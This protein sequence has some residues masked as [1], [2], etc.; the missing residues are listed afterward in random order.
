[1]ST[2]TFLGAAQRVTGSCYLIRCGERQ[3]LLECGMLQGEN[4]NGK[5]GKR[6]KSNNKGQNETRFPF[7]VGEIDAVI[8]SHA[9][10]DHSGMLPLL[11]KQGY[12][13]PIYMTLQTQALLPTMHK[14]AAF[15]QEK[16]AE[17]ENKRRARAGKKAVEPLFDIND[18]ERELGLC[19]GLAYGAESEI[20]PG[21]RLR[22]REA[23]HILGSAIVELWFDDKGETRKLVFS[24]DLGNSH[25]PLMRDPAIITEADLLLLESTYG[26]RDHQPLEQTLDE[27]R[28]ALDAAAASG[29]NV[30]IPSFAVGRTQDLIYHLGQLYH[31]GQLK[32][33]NIY[34]DSPMATSIS[35]IYEQN[36]SLFNKDDPEFRQIMTHDWQQWLPI[37]RFTRSVE[38]SMALNKITGGA[39]IIAGSGM[40][41]GGRIRHHLKYNLWRKNTHLIIVGFQARGTLGRLLVDGVKKVKI[42]GS[43][44]AVKARIHTLGGFSAHAG[45]SQLLEWAGHMRK[46]MPRLYL[47]HGE[48]ESMLALQKRFVEEFNWDASIPT[49]GEVIHF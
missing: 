20:L 21:I 25:A 2:L 6:K 45:Q 43:E 42:L 24:G 48:S 33:N 30:L 41:H 31:A 49:L 46:A 27:F 38:E 13:G 22:F 5:K 28:A 18:V 16:D 32:Q 23:G 7:E 8:I 3:L 11:A 34:I 9:H 15:L 40:C 35:E 47:V 26:N 37:L 10:L 19:H 17:W 29:G 39:I 44:I 4:S 36:T 1:M 12:S 14:D